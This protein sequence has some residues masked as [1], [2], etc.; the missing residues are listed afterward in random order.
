MS[1]L[2]L[3][4]ILPYVALG[5]ELS[6]SLYR[7]FGGSYKFSSLSSEFL[8]QKELF[9]GSTAWH[10]GILMVLLG[11]VLGFL[12]PKEVIAFGNVSW[13]LLVME[14]SALTFGLMALVGLVLL[15]RRRASRARIRAVTTKMDVFILLLLLIQ[16]ASGVGIAVVHRWGAMWYASA[17][18]PY[19]RSLF[20]LEP[21]IG[22]V[23]GMPPLVKLH[24]VNAYLILGILPFTRLVHFLV[25]PISYIWRSWQIVIWNYDRKKIRQVK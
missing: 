7:Y 8:E 1:D 21:N 3:F 18:V 14:T 15:V 24:L 13:R 19:L 22:L 25:L 10:Y 2:I 12:F 23:A 9:W 20:I 16:V 4:A 11:H 6:V 5:I 17:L